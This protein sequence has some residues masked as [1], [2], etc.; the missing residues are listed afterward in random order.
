MQPCTTQTAT[1][2]NPAFAAGY[3]IA[4]HCAVW[5]DIAPGLDALHEMHPDQ[6]WSPIDVRRMLDE[7]LAVLLV[8]DDD[9]TAFAIVYFG[10]YPYI[11]DR[12][13]LNVFLVWHKGGDAIERFQPHLEVFAQL[14]GAQHMRFYSR[15]AAFIRVA[16]RAGYELHGLEFVKELRH[17]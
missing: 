3:H 4:D 17:G 13:E 6:D 9:P 16:Q 12:T 8:D 5:S 14:G 2:I 1:P 7:D 11:E 10:K 15:R